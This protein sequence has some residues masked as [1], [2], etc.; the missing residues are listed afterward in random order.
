MKTYSADYLRRSRRGMWDEGLSEYVDVSDVDSALDVGC[1]EGSLTRALSRHAADVVGVDF[2]V[3]HLRSLGFAGV[4]GDALSLPFEPSSFDVVG[5]Q[6]LLVNLV[7]PRGAVDEMLRVSSDRVLVVEPDNHAAE[8]TSTVDGEAALA[9]RSRRRFVRGTDSRAG[10]GSDVVDVLGDAGG[11]VVGHSVHRQTTA[12]E[13]PYT[14][15]DLEAVAR[16]TRGEAFGGREF[17][18]PQ[19]ELD[20]L[21]DEWRDVGRRAARQMSEAV[22]RRRDVVPFH[23]VVAEPPA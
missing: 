18:V 9:E 21:R 12:V 22:Y 6:A 14:D 23:V 7:E 17:T 2:D 1:G 19:E 20:A 8:V 15:A 16:R 3:S 4:V 13:P 10:L 11:D 5:C